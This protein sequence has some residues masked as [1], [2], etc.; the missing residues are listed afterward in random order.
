MLSKG[1]MY[2][3]KIH[4]KDT[5]EDCIGYVQYLKSKHWSLLREH[6]LSTTKSCTVCGNKFCLQ[7]H[8][9]TYKTLGKEKDGDVLVL[10]KKCHELHHE[11]MRIEKE[12]K[13]SECKQQEPKKNKIKTKVKN[14]G[15]LH[16]KKGYRPLQSESKYI[17]VFRD[18]GVS[19]VYKNIPKNADCTKDA[20]TI[21]YF[22]QYSRAQ[23]WIKKMCDKRRKQL[24]KNNKDILGGT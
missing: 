1:F 7:L 13:N 22:N 11:T 18:G 19:M 10:C 24:L 3:K 4:C 23:K 15:Q 2:K 8:H 14:S 20:T 21:S 17:A 9:L 6:I 5:G 12:N 16:F